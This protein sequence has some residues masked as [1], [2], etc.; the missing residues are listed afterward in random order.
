MSDNS[1]IRSVSNFSVV[2]FESNSPVLRGVDDL[3]SSLISD[4]TLLPPVD[5]ISSQDEHDNNEDDLDMDMKDGEVDESDETDSKN[6]I[7]DDESDA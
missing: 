7:Q 6:E 2:L 5:F 1:D 4:D 3:L